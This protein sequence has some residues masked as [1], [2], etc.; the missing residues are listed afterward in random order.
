MEERYIDKAKRNLLR[1][2][3]IAVGSVVY[4]V[5]VNVF[6]VPHGFLSGGVAGM[7]IILQYITGIS[8]GYFVIIINIPVFI[9]GFKLINKDFTVFSFIGMLSMSLA[10]IFTKNISQFYYLKDP[11]VS[12]LCSG[13]LTGTGAGIIFKCRASQGGTDIIAVAAKKKLGMS[14][15][16]MTFMIN[17]IIVSVG[18]FVG[19]LE[20]AVYTMISMYM[21]CVVVDKAIQGFDRQ[22]ILFVVT[23]ES[24]D[25]EEAISKKL[26]R[27]VTYLYGEGAYT[28]SKKKIIYS[29]MNARQTEEAKEF[30][31][32]IDSHAVMS[33]MDASEVRGKG[34]KQAVF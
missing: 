19:S 22:K 26:G 14:V 4:S 13:I 16:R 3:L 27:G 17:V 31:G 21:Y 12:A 9:I 5:G 11:L 32:N 8:S 6:I 29:I 25:V 30:I 33:I 15:G 2:F 34:F 23:G 24:E 10:L 7:A 28:G 1:I 18:L 20:I